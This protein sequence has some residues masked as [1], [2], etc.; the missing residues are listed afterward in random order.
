ME[1]Y[2]SKAFL[3]ASGVKQTD[4]QLGMLTISLVNPLYFP[5]DITNMNETV[6]ISGM[7][8]ISADHNAVP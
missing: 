4:M 1:G 2:P 7:Q 3:D 8:R 5:K 6:G